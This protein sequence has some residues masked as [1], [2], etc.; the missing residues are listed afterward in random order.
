VYKLL[1]KWLGGSMGKL[2]LVGLFLF[3]VMGASTLSAATYNLKW[4]DPNNEPGTITAY[5]VYQGQPGAWIPLEPDV[6][7]GV[8]LLEGV[9]PNNGQCFTV[10]AINTESI[11]S[12][13]ADPP[14]CFPAPPTSVMIEIIQ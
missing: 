5:R 10:T 7:A 14:Y 1:L 2:V 8:T 12:G 4:D 13:Y 9:S 3:V 6:A 11:E